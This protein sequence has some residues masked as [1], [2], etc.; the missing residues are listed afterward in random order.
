[1]SDGFVPGFANRHQMAA[2]MLQRAFAMSDGFA[3]ATLASAR[4]DPSPFQ[5]DAKGPRHFSPAN[6]NHKATEGW[7]PFDATAATTAPGIDAIAEAHAAGYAEGLAAAHAERASE[8]ARDRKL[9]T[10][11]GVS[12]SA[13]GFVDRA[14]FAQRM[15]QTVLL[16]VTQLVGEIGVSGA[17]IAHRV[18]AAIE[19]LADE[20]ESA[21]LRLHPLDIALVEGKLPATVFP[22]GDAAVERG[23]FLIESASTIVEDGPSLWLEQL[24]SAID[25]VGVPATC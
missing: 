2:D 13:S 16:L 12:L 25:R 15:R 5:D 14:A 11:L 3:P 6:P 1:M 18:E 8:A 4:P 22:V 9:L 23:G 10:D 21:L 7:D 17:L 24:G 20:T 19:M